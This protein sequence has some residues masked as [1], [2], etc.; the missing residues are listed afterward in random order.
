MPAADSYYFGPFR[1]DARGHL[2][3]REGQMVPLAP[4]VVDVLQLLIENAGCVVE[5]DVLLRTVWRNAIVGENS[6]TRTISLL[7]SSLAAGNGESDY[8]VTIAK[9]GYRFVAPVTT[10]AAVAAVP[11][12]AKVML[13]VLPFDNLSGDPTQEYFSDGLTE[14]MI[15]QLSRL[16][17]ERLGVIARTSTMQYKATNKSVQQ[18]GSELGVGYVLEGSVRRFAKTVRITAQLVRVT[19]QTHVWAEIYDR[20][21]DDILAVQNEVAQAIAKQIPIELA[22]SSQAKVFDTTM[23]NPE[24]YQLCLKGRYFWYKRTERGLRKGIEYF[25]HA[26]TQAP[27]YAPAYA[28]LADC[29]ALLSCRGFVAP[30]DG[31]PRATVA[32]TNAIK[33][34]GALGEAHASL[35]HVRLHRCEW[36]DLEAALNHAIELNPSH[37]MNYLWYSEYLRVRG[38]F[39]E[40]IAILRRAQQLDP[41]SP[42]VP[43]SQAATHYF[44]REYDRAVECL[45][46][47]LELDP[48]FFLTHFRRGQ[49]A[50]GQRRYGEAIHSMQMAVALAER[51]AEMLAG[52]GQAYA[53]DGRGDDLREVLGELEHQSRSRYVSA[54]GMARI[55]APNDREQAIAW[56]DRAY[57]EGSADLIE[58]AVEPAFDGVRSDSRF[59]ALV[60]RVG[61]PASPCV[62]GS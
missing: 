53:A 46:D 50:L 31:F 36:N 13:A 42:I 23:V 35:A 62:S 8:V 22:P 45:D 34:D 54:Y 20:K 21:L 48:T 44:A 2:L 4:K 19:D 6:L 3:F 17:P 28:G 29:F 52:L 59:V 61:L 43:C 47:A 25:D 5:K 14:E 56:L 32:A 57:E 16:S 40:S 26:I 41:L 60:R 1:L 49:V 9:R 15:T 38:R 7:R 37:A 55:F 30:R 18:I 51:S 10:V 58:V 39:A 12:P 33:L 27:G 11:S 24:A